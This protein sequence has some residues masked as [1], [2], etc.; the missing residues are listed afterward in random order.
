MDARN[1]DNRLIYTGMERCARKIL[2]DEKLAT[3]DEVAC[4]TSVE[5]CEKLLEH[6]EV[7]S[8][9]VEKIT[10]VKHEN[11]STYNAIVRNLSR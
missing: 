2:I 3:V 4:M 5:V 11:M 6:Y 8:C 9:E 7:V 10:I 1:L